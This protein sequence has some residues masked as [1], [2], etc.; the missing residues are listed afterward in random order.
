MKSYVSYASTKELLLIELLQP[1]LGLG[2]HTFSLL[3]YT[4][5][6]VGLNVKR[7]SKQES[8]RAPSVRFYQQSAMNL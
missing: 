1:G 4:V 2:F 7:K 5:T 6:N 8:S 3:Q